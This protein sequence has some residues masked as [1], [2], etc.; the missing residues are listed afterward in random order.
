MK[1]L[2][3]AGN[4]ES[5]KAAVYNGADE[6][7]LGINEFN[8][9][10]NIDGFT[11]DSLKEAVDFSHLYGVKV[12]LAINILFSDDEMQKAVDVVVKAYN[13]GIDAFIVQDLGLATIL[14]DNYPD[15]VLHA[16]TQMG[17][18]NLE[19]VK[20]I[21][22]FGFKRVVLSRETDLNEIVRIKDNTD[23]EIEYFVQGAL[24]VSFSG[25]CYLSSYLLNASGNRGRCKQLCR[26][27]FSFQKNNKIIKSGYLLSAKDFNMIN[28]ISDLKKAGVTSL[29]IEGRARRPYYVAMTTREY[30]NAVNGKPVN[31][32]NLELAFNRHYTE[33][34]FNGNSKII[35]DVQNH[36]GIAVGRVEKFVSGNKF[37]ELHVKADFELK[38]KSVLKFFEGKKEI[39]T[40][41]AYD[42][43]SNKNGKYIITTTR[44]IKEGVN[45]R[46]ISDILEEQKILK[47]SVKRKFD[48][49]LSVKK[50]Y[51]ITASVIVNGQKIKVCGDICLGAVNKPLLRKEFEES[52]S[53]NEYFIANIKFLNFENVFMPKSALNS[54][55]RKVFEK[56][57]LALINTNTQELTS[58]I[59]SI[60]PNVK[61]F[62]DYCFV[63]SPN[64]ACN[65]K[66]VIYSPEE[67]VLSDISEFLEKCKTAG[68]TPYL[69]T[70]NFALRQD[71]EKLKEI[72]IK[73][74]IGVVANNYYALG[75]TENI[76][77]GAGL[78]V[79]NNTTAHTLAKPFIRAE[80]KTVEKFSYPYMTLRHCPIK[81]HVGGNCNSCRYE[82]GYEYVME[83]GRKLKLK[84]K[85][86]STCTFYLTN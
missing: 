57:Y 23:I 29:K 6:V 19:G 14:N 76:V 43:K 77:I 83:G 28:R 12:F 25:N 55:R 31:E 32:Q 80:G 65:E 44:K 66:N 4:M 68:K 82:D 2:S 30:Y 73:T 49:N 36:I 27:P 37:N 15:V 75:L 51:P 7:Y 13:I 9:R 39:A 26:L 69:D 40:L 54:F 48:I 1:I 60:K 59:V 34:Y 11:M 18:H 16:S 64:F 8:A 79:Y 21:A 46:L 86:L 58:V 74:G 38:P 22:K 41:T 17:I 67:Y 56:V 33:G 84:R 20:E 5:L 3:P 70:P 35:S 72:I 71:V 42:V 78:N 85:K 24:C 53:K 10:N 61:E 81:E 63:N 52:F 50:D 62:T 45:V 47:Q